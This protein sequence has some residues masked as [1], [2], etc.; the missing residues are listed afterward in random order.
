[1]ALR[2]AAILLLAACAQAPESAPPEWARFGEPQP[3]VIQ[4]YDGDAMEPFLARDGGVLFFNNSNAPSAQ[5]DLHW[6]ERVDET[7][8]QYRGPLNGA[9]G[10]ALDAVASMSADNRF[11]F[12]STRSYETTLG[13]VYCATWRDGSLEAAALQEDVSARIPG[14]LMFDLEI[15]ADAATLIVADGEFRG[16]AMPAS[17]DLRQARWRDGRF[18][19]TPEDDA[20]FAAVNT[21]ALEYAAAISADGLTLAFTRLEGQ[22]P[23]VRTSIWLARRS[24]SNAA[25]E[26]PVRLDTIE[27]EL[28]EGPTFSPDN[29]AIYY[30]QKTG[31]HY[32]IWRV[33]R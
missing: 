30:H 26:P 14:R 16:G 28:I 32:T 33:A 25:F 2:W 6:A 4:G 11:C 29:N 1:M 20:L 12:I 9:N 10:T 19:L 15:A 5:T 27:G 8:F 24:E 13:T 21:R 17:A 3:V 31:D 23:F 7:T 18:V 22:F